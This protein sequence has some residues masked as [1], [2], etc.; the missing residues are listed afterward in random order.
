[1]VGAVTYIAFDPTSSVPFTA[2][3]IQIYQWV[4]LPQE[5]FRRSP[6]LRSSS[7]SASC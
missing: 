3:P 1:M 7:C 2:L 4:R 5:E 6:R